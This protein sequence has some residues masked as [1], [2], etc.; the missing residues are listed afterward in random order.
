MKLSRFDIPSRYLKFAQFIFLSLTSSQVNLVNCPLDIGKSMGEMSSTYLTY[1]PELFKLF[2][3][4]INYAI[5][6]DS[7][8]ILHN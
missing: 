4:M 6:D 1:P 7:G 2:I 5:V 3:F 8:G